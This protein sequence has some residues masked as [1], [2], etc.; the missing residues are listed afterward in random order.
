MSELEGAPPGPDLTNGVAAGD[1]ADGAMLVGHVG[2]AAVLVAR[3]AGNLSAIGA[4]CS[5]YHGPLGEGLSVGETVRCPWHHARFCLRAGEARGAPAIDPVGG[6]VGV[7]DGKAKGE[8][9]VR[10]VAATDVQQ[11]GDRG[12][13]G[14]DGGV[15]PGIAQHAGEVG[16]FGGAGAGPGWGSAAGIGAGVAAVVVSATVSVASGTV[17]LL[18]FVA[19]F[20]IVVLG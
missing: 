12:R 1:V 15:L 11:P 18:L 7:Q 3:V 9:R 2:E 20:A 14:E 4:E 17:A 10:H 5:H 8:G 6:G 16:A 13:I 19:I